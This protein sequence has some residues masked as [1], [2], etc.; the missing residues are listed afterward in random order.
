MYVKDLTQDTMFIKRVANTGEYLVD[1]DVK[2]GVRTIRTTKNVFKAQQ[3][4]L[5]EAYE[6]TYNDLGERERERV[7]EAHDKNDSYNSLTYYVRDSFSPLEVA[8]INYG[9]NSDIE[10]EKKLLE[11]MDIGHMVTRSV[12]ITETV[13]QVSEEEVKL[14]DGN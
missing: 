10:S 4:T 8:D 7:L 14:P 6:H 11:S 2:D 9:Y 5:R 12:V 13:D 3:F 1:M